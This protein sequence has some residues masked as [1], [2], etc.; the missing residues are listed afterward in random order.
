ME[1]ELRR[2]DMWSSQPPSPEA[3][4]SQQPF[5]IDTLEFHEWLQFILISRMKVIIE[6]D[7]PLPQASG[8]LPMAEE[9]YK[10]ELEQVDALLDVIRRFDDLIMEYHG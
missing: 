6:A 2:L 10:Q 9:R 4:A 1:A 3:L 5:C 7:A 8:I